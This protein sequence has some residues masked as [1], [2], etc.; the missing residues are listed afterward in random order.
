MGQTAWP[1]TC[2]RPLLETQLESDWLLTSMD[3]SRLK[4]A[5]DSFRFWFSPQ[6]D[7]LLSLRV[8]EQQQLG[9]SQV[10]HLEGFF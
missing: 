4:S 6:A 3:L 1:A 8:V 7:V 5:S 9:R 2:W 10:D